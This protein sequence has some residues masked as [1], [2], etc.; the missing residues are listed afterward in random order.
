MCLRFGEPRHYK[1]RFDESII[2]QGKMDAA[3]SE[4][5]DEERVA[6]VAAAEAQ[7]LRLRDVSVDIANRQ[8]DFRMS[9]TTRM[10]STSGTVVDVELVTPEEDSKHTLVVSD[11]DLKRYALT[12]DELVSRAMA[13]MLSKRVK[14]DTKEEQLTTGTFPARYF[15]V[16]ML[17]QWFGDEVMFQGNPGSQACA[18]IPPFFY[19]ASHRKFLRQMTPKP[20]ANVSLLRETCTKGG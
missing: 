4:L 16:A 9:T 1:P 10:T 6:L 11:A 8:W 14:R 5:S 13:L 7:A 12:L 18:S 17:E 15:A 2:E 20:S 19:I 3:H